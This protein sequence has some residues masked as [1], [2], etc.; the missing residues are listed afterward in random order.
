MKWD[1][2]TGA[3]QMSSDGRYTIQHAT[4]HNWVAYAIPKYGMA[5]KLGERDSDVKAR[6]CCIAHEATLYAKRTA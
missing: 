2:P 5:E 1:K 3:I 4:E 6:A